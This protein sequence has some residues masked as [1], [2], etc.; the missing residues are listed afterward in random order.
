MRSRDLMGGTSSSQWR[1]VRGTCSGHRKGTARSNRVMLTKR[2]VMQLLA[3]VA[4]MA[5]P[6]VMR[7]I[8][9]ITHE[10]RNE[11]RPRRE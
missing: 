7:L 4:V 5:L 1:G 8:T 3:V 6:R 9:L 10:M 2:V 11:L